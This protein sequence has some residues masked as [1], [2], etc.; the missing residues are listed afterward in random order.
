MNISYTEVF[1][2]HVRK[3]SKRYRS[4]QNDLEPVLKELEEGVLLGDRITGL[5]EVLYKIRV[6]NSDSQKGKSGGYRVI[7][8]LKK[9]DEIKM[10]AMYAKSDQA[11]ISAAS[12]QRIL[13]D[14]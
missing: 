13:S 3:L 7:Y 8:Y 2:K 1:K 4:L 5:G 6:K 10:M 11:N 9:V 12:L 14:D